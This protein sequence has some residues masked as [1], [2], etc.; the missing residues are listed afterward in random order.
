MTIENHISDLLYRYECVILPGFGAFLT[1]KESA[2]LD[3][4][5]HKFF[6]PKKTISFNSQ[7]KKNDG[8][9]ANYIAESLDIPYPA[10][11]YKIDAF[12]EELNEKLQKK[13]KFSLG[14]IGALFLSEE[15]NIQ[16]EP[17]DQHNYLTSAFGLQNI[18]AIEVKREVFKKE[19]Q[20]L[21][22]KAAFLF[23]PE[24]RNNRAY[25]KYAAIGILAIG[26]SGLVGLNIYSNSV[27][28]HN[29]AE[30]RA[31]QSQLQQ[32]I[33]E[34]TFVVDNPLPEITL[35]V[36]NQSGNYHVVAGAFRIEENAHEKVAELRAEGFKARY[37]GAN[38]YGLHQVVYSSFKTRAEA[39]KMLR[40]VKPENE[41][42][43]LLIQEL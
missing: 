2:Y 36:S 41:G 43:W 7:L 38:K 10:A 28:Q 11:V 27:S 14:N 34:A 22:E 20:E 6:P 17:V 18:P 1:Q 35:T 42:A 25:L 4:N 33:Q 13:E 21:E 23:T 15:G 29:I 5:A 3:T 30:Q 8:L 16:F 31:A 37:I 24:R 9:L 12:V 19:T 32:K 40:Q 26:L 39:L